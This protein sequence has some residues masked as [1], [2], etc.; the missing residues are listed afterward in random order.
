MAG[1]WFI[2][3]AAVVPFRRISRAVQPH[4][5]ITM[6]AMREPGR[7]IF[8]ARSGQAWIVRMALTLARLRRCAHH[9]IP[10]TIVLMSAMAGNGFVAGPL[11]IAAVSQPPPVAITVVA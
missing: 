7:P 6:D 10:S 9:G 3:W 2:A 5:S 1:N 11:A 4:A 8:S